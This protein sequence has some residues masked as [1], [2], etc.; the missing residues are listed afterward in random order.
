M[1]LFIR[2]VGGPSKSRVGRVECS[3]SIPQ[4]C[5][6]QTDYD[7]KNESQEQRP[8]QDVNGVL[9]PYVRWTTAAIEAAFGSIKRSRG[10]AS[11][12]I[13]VTKALTFCLL[14]RPIYW[15][16]HPRKGE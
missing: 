4:N 10:R 13:N 1:S 9:L 7:E 12:P 16:I 5:D 3:A 2:R 14:A 15:T 6:D 11:L 8:R